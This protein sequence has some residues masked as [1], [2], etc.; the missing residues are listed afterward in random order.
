MNDDKIT[1]DVYK[2]NGLRFG[3]NLIKNQQWVRE[4]V[5]RIRGSSEPAN[6]TK[7]VGGSFNFGLVMEFVEGG[8][9]WLARFPNM[10]MVMFPDEKMLNEIAI[11]E[12]LRERTSLPVP[13]VI[14]YSLTDQ[15]PHGI[16]PY[17]ITTFIRGGTRLID[18]LRENPA[19]RASALN[20]GLSEEV[21]VKAY[22]AMAIITLELSRCV[23]DRIGSIEKTFS[24]G[25]AGWNV[26][27]RRPVTH[28]MNE[29]V[30]CCG[31]PPDLLVQGS[32]DM[33]D[34]YFAALVD[35]RMLQLLAQRN[36]AD[37]MSRK[38]DTR[39]YMDLCAEDCKEKFLARHLFRESV[40]PKFTAPPS[41]PTA[42]LFCDDLSPGNVLVD[43]DFNIIAVL[44]CE[45]SYAAP[46]QYT[47]SPPWL[48]IWDHGKT[49]FVDT[50]RPKFELLL[51][52]L[53]E[54]EDEAAIANDDDGNAAFADYKLPPRPR[55]SELMK[56]SWDDGTF[57][58]VQGVRNSNDFDQIY[59]DC[60]DEHFRGTRASELER[61][62]LLGEETR[63]EMEL[64]VEKKL[65]DLKLYNAELE[66]FK[67]MKKMEEES[68][69][70]EK[71]EEVE[72]KNAGE[73]VEVEG[74]TEEKNEG[75]SEE[76]EAEEGEH[77]NVEKEVEVKRQTKEGTEGKK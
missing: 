41:L 48:L 49:N 76:K 60:L 18:L 36:A 43:D 54:L 33:A 9:P 70:G 19:D 26:E 50:Y 58:F 4:E 15:S 30:R 3:D 71:T 45:F 21:L 75:K 29:T 14:T 25:R 72:H 39:D 11:M 7:L 22:R 8:E 74:Q 56:Q 12:Y 35:E 40:L 63:R 52:V 65:E 47:C 32:F 5:G 17:M 2:K 77:Q 59:W 38:D 42:A 31:M 44:D 64:L 13:E 68:Q 6:I 66:V 16:G 28:C 46:Y 73:E 1:E 53:R 61:E 23:F 67:K 24:D 51:K 10:D 62:K 55:L 34:K 57:W 37:F 69:E 27:H 20:L